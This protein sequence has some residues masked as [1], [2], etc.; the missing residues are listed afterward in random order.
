[1]KI[2]LST[3]QY[4]TMAYRTDSFVGSEQDE[5]SSCG[6]ESFQLFSWP[7]RLLPYPCVS[8]HRHAPTCNYLYVLAM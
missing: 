1:M 5:R 8:K 4:T 7:H 6:T 2:T 3:P